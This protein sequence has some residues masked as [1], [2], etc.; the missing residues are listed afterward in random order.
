MRHNQATIGQFVFLLLVVIFLQAAQSPA[1]ADG[2]EDARRRGQLLAGVKTDFPP[3]GYINNG[4]YSGFDIEIARYFAKAFF[5]DERR[6]NFVPVTSGS[7]IPFLYSGWIDLLVA[8]MTITDD[9]KR[10]LE[11]SEPYFV[12]GSLFLVTQSSPVSG[13]EDLEGKTVAVI[14]GS[15]QAEDLKQIAPQVELRS[16]ATVS[17]AL[18]SLKAGDVDAFC[19][20][21]VLVLKLAENDPDLQTVGKPFIPR[22]YAVA[23]RKGEVEFITWINEQLAKMKNDGTYQRLWEKYFGDIEEHLIKP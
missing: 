10:V 22:P 7:R 15:I 11:F 20:D 18:Q 3:F 13:L 4:K 5:N 9:R 1:F 16:F 21:D 14:E 17:E 19:Q 6:V 2:L 8:T 23:V 12:S